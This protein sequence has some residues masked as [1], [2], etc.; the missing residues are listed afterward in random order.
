MRAI[1]VEDNET[2]TLIECEITNRTANAIEVIGN[3]S[4]LVWL[5]LSQC[6]IEDEWPGKNFEQFAEV[7]VPNWLISKNP[8]L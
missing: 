2:H 6:T 4:K 5:P 3:E 1:I 7:T 8:L